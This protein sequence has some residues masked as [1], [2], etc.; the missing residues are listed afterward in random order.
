MALPDNIPDLPDMQAQMAD[1]QARQDAFARGEA[2]E[3][4]SWAEYTPLI[5]FTPFLKF[6][7][8]KFPSSWAA[9]KASQERYYN[10]RPVPFD[11][12]RWVVIEGDLYY[13]SKRNDRLGD[14]A[15]TYLH[16]LEPK[17]SFGRTS[18]AYN[19]QW[20][21]W[22]HQYQTETFQKKLP[23]RVKIDGATELP[24]NFSLRMP[25]EY[26]MAIREDY[27]W[28]R[29]GEP[30]N[31][32]S[33]KSQKATF[34][35]AK[36]TPLTHIQARPIVEKVLD[37]LGIKR[38]LALVQYLQSVG[39]LESGYGRG[40][41]TNNWGSV[42]C[43]HAPPCVDGECVVLEDSKPDGTK[44]Q[45][46]YRVYPTPYDGAK[47][48]IALV[49]KKWPATIEQARKGNTLEA[50]SALHG[51]Y[52]GKGTPEQ[53]KKKHAADVLY[54][55]KNIAAS[56]GEKLE[57]RALTGTAAKDT[58]SKKGVGVAVVLGAIIVG[59]LV[60]SRKK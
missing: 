56:L 44:Y 22:I 18:G 24:A 37:D 5:I 58:V 31:P 11:P 51:Y 17:G 7:I 20:P 39:A 6:F 33:A 15:S 12:T 2:K 35:I 54:N 53:A 29:P 40:T 48:M 34:E 28:T 38:N 9:G 57:L 10:Q 1:A 60:L 13:F 3:L 55:A 50:S 36:P 8:D 23:W 19:W 21:G 59:G 49:V 25:P 46:C 42:Q 52:E 45:W 16:G 27:G 14:L 4:L 41:A 32:V 26:E 47:A 30:S 43:S